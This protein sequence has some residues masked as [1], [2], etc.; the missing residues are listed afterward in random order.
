M[1]YACYF[2]PS[3]VVCCIKV[4]LN[5]VQTFNKVWTLLVYHIKSHLNPR[6]LRLLTKNHVVVSELGSN[7]NFSENINESAD[8]K[9][10]LKTRL[11]NTSSWRKILRGGNKLSV[12][13]H[14]WLLPWS[15]SLRINPLEW[16][17]NHSTQS[18]A[19]FQL[20][21][22]TASQTHKSARCSFEEARQNFYKFGSAQLLAIQVPS[23]MA[24]RLDIPSV[25]DVEGEPNIP[26]SQSSPFQRPECIVQFDIIMCKFWLFITDWQGK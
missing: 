9:T 3:D 19:D 8:P 11:I 23:S 15:L 25:Y 17:A 26:I 7:T 4:M 1:D 18:R 10:E 2:R 24:G 21:I 20:F 16:E 22:S 12:P 13:S 5:T 14:Y 6:Q